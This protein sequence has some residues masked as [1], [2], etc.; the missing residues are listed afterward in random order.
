M[1]PVLDAAVEHWPTAQL[2]TSMFISAIPMI[3]LRH[4]PA[5]E[6]QAALA[7][8][9]A[10]DAMLLHSLCVEACRI[11]PLHLRISVLADL[12]LA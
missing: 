3:I 4:H 7:L 8:T 12:D 1:C 9:K 2:D 6:W 11:L 10:A 5:A